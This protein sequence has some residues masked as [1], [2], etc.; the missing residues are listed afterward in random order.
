MK[1]SF[2]KNYTKN[3][4]LLEDF[5]AYNYKSD[6]RIQM[7]SN[8]SIPNTLDFSY[9]IVD[10]KPI[11]KYDITSK[12][13]FSSLFLTNSI[14]YKAYTNIILSLMDTIGFL[15]EYLININ[16]LLIDENYIYLDPEKYSTSFI[17]CPALDFNF[18]A[19]L[20]TF[21]E[22]ILKKIDHSDDQL[23]LLA[24]RLSSEAAKDGFNISMLKSI[25]LSSNLSCKIPNF[26]E[27]TTS[28]SLFTKNPITTSNS[29][30]PLSNNLNNIPTIIN[31][32]IS[33]LDKSNSIKL[34][35]NN[36]SN[37][38]DTL[39]PD[40]DNNSTSP[41]LFV[42]FKNLN[43]KYT[44]MHNTPEKATTLYT[45]STSFY[46]K[47]ALL[48]G[49]F[50][51]LLISTAYCK[52]NNYISTKLSILLVCIAIVIITGSIKYLYTIF[53]SA[54]I[55]Q[56]TQPFSDNN[57]IYEND[58]VHIN[59]ISDNTLSPTTP[60][61]NSSDQFQEFGNTTILSRQ[62]NTSTI[63]RL[64]Y[65]GTDYVDNVPINSY[66]FTIGKLKN[67]TNMI[68]NN[69]LISR[70]HA[71]IYFENNSYY[72]EDMNSSN[73]TYVNDTLLSP[74]EKFKLLEGDKITFS[75]LTYIFE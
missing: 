5:P 63:H 66:P 38:L 22:N 57:F 35:E 25:V 12:Q 30:L 47:S 36:S 68:I 75:H 60:I 10:N 14:N 17:I 72:I 31:H 43:N 29:S 48:G 2:T 42:S 34:S 26:S 3:Y 51:L 65:T 74:H 19:Q 24:Y 53:P 33:F 67:S 32:D 40:T 6:F 4:I 21:F 73:G 56:K 27:N 54:K 13:S 37:N 9:T 69:P 1:T 39:K 71:C 18:Y 49:I 23:V 11:F 7:L 50:V 64:V 15:E 16:S 44:V 61:Y 28:N 45:I 41:K 59:T 55:P 8:N 62:N 20:S 52:V 58:S 70:I 46:I